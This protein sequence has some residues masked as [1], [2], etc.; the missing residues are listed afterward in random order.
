MILKN[1]IIIASASGKVFAI[2]K[3]NGN[4]VWEQYLNTNQNPLVNGNSIFLVHNNKELI[5][6]DLNNGKIR[7]I[8]EIAKKYSNENNNIWLNPVLINNKLVTVGGNKSLIIFNPY[9]GEI[10]KKTSLPDIPLTSPIIVKKRV[11]L[12]FKNSAIFSIE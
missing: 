7:W 9:N 6:L 12:M 8:T 5:N 3:K 4:L 1:I 10:E 2:N 11:F